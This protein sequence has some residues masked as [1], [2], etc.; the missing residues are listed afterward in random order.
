MT[1]DDGAVGVAIKEN[2]TLVVR[3][4]AEKDTAG[5]ARGEFVWGGG[6]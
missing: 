3:G 2:I 4:V 5:G 1:R 6:R